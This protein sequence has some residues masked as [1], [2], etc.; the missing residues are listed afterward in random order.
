MLQ[1]AL[2]PAEAVPWISIGTPRLAGLFA[3]RN[4][5]GMQKLFSSGK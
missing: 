5:C 3:A 1:P 2:L 4:L